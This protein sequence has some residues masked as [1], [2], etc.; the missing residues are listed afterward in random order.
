MCKK[1]LTHGLEV[2]TA[3][4]PQND[5]KATFI[6]YDSRRGYRASRGILRQTKSQGRT[7]VLVASPSLVPISAGHLQRAAVLGIQ[8]ERGSPSARG[9]LLRVM[10]VQNNLHERSWSSNIMGGDFIIG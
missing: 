8:Q 6:T 5:G 1:F 7:L 3:T 2:F 4:T 9:T 10:L